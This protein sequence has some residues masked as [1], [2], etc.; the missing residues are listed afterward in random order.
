MIDDCGTPYSLWFT[1]FLTV[2]Q[3]FRLQSKHGVVWREGLFAIMQQPDRSSYLC[4]S[5]AL[6]V[7]DDEMS[8]RTPLET[9]TSWVQ[10][11]LL[12]TMVPQPWRKIVEEGRVLPWIECGGVGEGVG[13]RK[14]GWEEF[15]GRRCKVGGQS[16]ST[17]GLALVS[18]GNILLVTGQSRF[19]DAEKSY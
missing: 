19:R 8:C 12:V 16:P 11:H 14:W 17:G 1:F 6:R 3:H 9:R 7:P 2:K 13:G 15:S 5:P 18:T 10:A 4:F